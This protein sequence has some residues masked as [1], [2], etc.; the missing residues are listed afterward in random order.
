[1]VAPFLWDVILIRRGENENF[2][3][4]I[5]DTRRVTERELS[6]MGKNKRKRMSGKKVI[7]EI[8]EGEDLWKIEYSFSSQTVKIKKNGCFRNNDVVFVRSGLSTP[9]HF[10]EKCVNEVV[11]TW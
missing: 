7:W 10:I 4:P 5:L 3:K 1:V 9:L 8:T 11:S 6:E 2:G